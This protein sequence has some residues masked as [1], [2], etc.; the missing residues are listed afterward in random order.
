MLY[1]EYE[2]RVGVW[3]GGDAVTM[4]MVCKPPLTGGGIT[5]GGVR[6][7]K[8]EWGLTRVKCHVN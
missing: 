6:E 4:V 5:G 7:G 2:S 3:L 8:E 1:G